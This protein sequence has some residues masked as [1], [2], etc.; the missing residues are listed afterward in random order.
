M[1]RYTDKIRPS[2]SIK[3]RNSREQLVKNGVKKCVLRCFLKVAAVGHMY[4][5]I[6]VFHLYCD[7]C[8]GVQKRVLSEIS[9]DIFFAKTKASVSSTA[10]ASDVKSVTDKK[11][12]Q[13]ND[14][15][16]DGEDTHGN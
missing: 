11:T 8:L 5:L 12:L 15:D 2:R 14:S 7:I 4:I 10:S 1:R 13:P 6:S 16:S 9:S 3:V